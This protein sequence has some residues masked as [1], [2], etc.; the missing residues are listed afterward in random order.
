MKLTIMGIMIITVAGLPL[1]SQS[2]TLGTRYIQGMATD[3][4]FRDNNKVAFIDVEGK[5]EV[6]RYEIEYVHKIPFMRIYKGKK[7]EEYLVLYNEDMMILYTKEENSP[8][9]I[10]IKS[11][12][13]WNQMGFFPPSD[14]IFAS[15][16]LKEGDITYTVKNL[17][18]IDL[19]TPWVEGA[20]GNG[21]G[22]SITIKNTVLD[23]LILFSGYL[24]YKKPYLYTQNARPKK[25]RVACK[26]IG[27]EKVFD[28]AD[29]P[30]PQ[31]LEFG[32]LIDMKDITIT[33]IDVYPGTKYEDMCIH[34]IWGRMVTK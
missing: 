22:E 28:V 14:I 16:E 7:V 5:E 2:I 1:Y 31:V 18:S 9:D 8:Y 19:E 29:T 12:K 23:S 24:S 25:I 27:F 26:E 21:I 15:S 10:W 30:N 4:E 34:A 11:F 3:V 32:R 13:T 33:I 6:Y 20:K 17:R